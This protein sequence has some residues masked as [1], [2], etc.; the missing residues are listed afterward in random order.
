MRKRIQTRLQKLINS[1]RSPFS[2][3][4]ADLATP[5]VSSSQKVDLAYETA[6]DWMFDTPASIQEASQGMSQ[7]MN[8]AVESLSR[9]HKLVASI[10]EASPTPIELRQSALDTP[11]YADRDLFDGEIEATP[12]L[13]ESISDGYADALFDEPKTAPTACPAEPNRYAA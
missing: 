7:N 3:K 9:L 4:S 6:D 1:A 10:A 2:K 12:P 8:R 11:L 5:E 13:Q